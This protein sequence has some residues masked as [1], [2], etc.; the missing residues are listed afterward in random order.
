MSDTLFRSDRL[1]KQAKAD[2]I[3]RVPGAP[4]DSVVWEHSVRVSRLA[5]AIARSPELAHE[6]IDPAALAGAAFYQDSGWVLQVRQGQIAAR[7]LLLRPTSDLQRELAADWMAQRLNG[8]LSPGSLQTAIRAVRQCNDRRTDLPEARILADAE[9]LDDIGPQTICLLIRRLIADGRTL[10]DLV[11]AWERQQEY[12]YWQ[13]RIKECFHFPS[14]RSIADGRYEAMQQFMECLRSA[15]HLA[16]VAISH[17]LGN[18][19]AP[20]PAP[21][22]VRH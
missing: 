21:A 11:A 12:H 2:L 6:S 9:N 22:P 10:I 1:E 17:P 5:A 4:D 8:I 18:K 20:T 16:D 7:D 14:S 15:V 19:S 13:A 3:V